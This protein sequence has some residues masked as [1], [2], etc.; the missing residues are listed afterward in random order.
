LNREIT[1]SIAAKTRERWEEHV[2]FFRHKTNAHK[3]WRT[4]RAID[5]KSSPTAENEAIHFKTKAFSS[6]SDIAKGFN[7]Q[8]TTSKTGPH[9]SSKETRQLIRLIQKGTLDDALEF[10]PD[11]VIKGIKSCNNS[12]AFGPDGLTIFHL[13]HL[14]PNGVNFLT[15]LFNISLSTSTIPAIWKM[16]TVIPIPKP[17]KDPSQGTSYRPISLLCPAAKVLEALI[18]PTLTEHLRP[19]AEQHGFRAKHSTT[20]ALVNLTT[21]IAEG[22]N[23]RKPPSRTVA[24]AVDLTAAFDTVSHNKL[25]AK[26]AAST[27][28]SSLI[29]WLACYLRGRQARTSFRGVKSPARIIHAGVPQGSKISPV[30]FNFYIADLPQPTPPV[31]V[32]AYADDI[33]AYATGPAV[34]A[35][36][37]ALNDY[38]EDLSTFLSDNSLIIS[39]PKS[40]V[41]LF[42]P[43]PAQAK[44]HPNVLINGK[45]LP[46]S[47]TPKILGVTLDT[48]FTFNHH[49]TAIA[50]KIGK[51]NTILKALAGSTWGQQKETLLLTYKAINQSVSD[52]A[53]SVYSLNAS[54]TNVKKIQT[55]QNDGLRIATGAHRMASIDH[56]HQESL[57]LPVQDHLDMLS[58]QYLASSTQQE[59][60]CHSVTTRPP[61]PRRM[62][63]TLATKHQNMVRPLLVQDNHKAT[64][65][66]IHTVA[67]ANTINKQSA[68][69][70][71]GGRPPP[72][73]KEESNLSRF[74]R[75]T[76][77]QLRSGYCRLL[78]SYRHR[79][80]PN[81]PDSCTDCGASPHD[82]PH[83][84]NC[85]SHPTTLTP[86]DLWENPAA[87]IH[88]LHFLHPD[89]IDPGGG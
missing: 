36:E 60:P 68:N 51:R 39:E 66:A 22:F 67:V 11:Q 65:K 76:L 55:A 49:C 24:V 3:L 15:A 88:H 52:Y 29:R 20:S 17:G 83:L 59:H 7:K 35:L 85:P 6:P 8:F 12:K 72:I 53:A 48:F 27:L 63:E 75:T 74:Q 86:E 25:L 73:N 44:Y 4:I 30:L 31:K 19:A 1:A 81:T 61:P 40:T 26:I 43:D 2:S 9:K 41:T 28:P 56:L 23:Q 78:N 5:G 50:Q 84:F 71:L 69:V 87:A 79:L 70:L 13:K 42:S 21:D 18:L 33:T 77:C 10:T 14:G 82:V 38:L 46:L 37:T 80:D 89:L 57:M 47:K 34:P 45:Q 64:I 62:K 54:R 58:A 16:S 32:I